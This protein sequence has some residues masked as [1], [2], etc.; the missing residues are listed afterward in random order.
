MP[1]TASAG[2]V[3]GKKKLS[4]WRSLQAKKKSKKALNPAVI[5]ND[6]GGS[7]A[8]AAV[9]AR[10]LGGE[11][12][13]QAGRVGVERSS[14]EL[15]LVEAKAHAETQMNRLQEVVVSPFVV[16]A[17][18]VAPET[19]GAPA[20]I[21][22][23]TPAGIKGAPAQIK[24][25]PAVTVTAGAGSPAATAGAD[26]KINADVAIDEIYSWL[27][28]AKPAWSTT[29][30]GGERNPSAPGLEC[31]D[32]G[33]GPGKK[34]VFAALLLPSGAR[35]GYG[36]SG[37][38]VSEG[39]ALG[40]V[41]MPMIPGGDGVQLG[42]FAGAKGVQGGA[43][44]NYAADGWS[45][46]AGGA[47]L[48]A[49]VEALAGV[50]VPL[51]PQWFSKGDLSA[52]QLLSKEVP[53]GHLG[54]SDSYTRL[55]APTGMIAATSAAGSI[56]ASSAAGSTGASTTNCTAIVKPAQEGSPVW[57]AAKEGPGSLEDLGIWAEGSAAGT[58]TRSAGKKPWDE[59]GFR[60]NME[61]RKSSEAVAAK[62]YASTGGVAG[63]AHQR[64]DERRRQS[65][66]DLNLN[67]MIAG[68][69]EAFKP[70]EAAPAAAVATAALAAA[71]GGAAAAAAG[72]R[73]TAAQNATTAVKACNEVAPQLV[74]ALKQQAGAVTEV[75]LVGAP[76]GSP[77]VEAGPATALPKAAAAA[78]PSTPE[79]WTGE[80][81]SKAVEGA[82]PV[83]A[84]LATAT[85]ASRTTAKRAQAPT[86]AKDDSKEAG[87][88]NAAIVGLVMLPS[89]PQDRGTRPSAVAAGPTC[90]AS[91]AADGGA[92]DAVVKE[93]QE[94][95]VGDDEVGIKTMIADVEGTAASILRNSS[96]SSFTPEEQ[97]SIRST[98]K[99][100]S[101]CSARGTWTAPVDSEIEKAAATASEQTSLGQAAVAGG[102]DLLLGDGI[103]P[104]DSS[105]EQPPLGSGCGR[106]RVTA[107]AAGD[108]GASNSRDIEV[109]TA[110]IE[111]LTT[112][113]LAD[114][115]ERRRTLGGQGGSSPF[116]DPMS[117]SEAAL[118]SLDDSSYNTTGGDLDRSRLELTMQQS[119]A[120]SAGTTAAQA[121]A[122]EARRMIAEA[123]ADGVSTAPTVP[124]E[125]IKRLTVGSA[126]VVNPAKGESWMDAAT[127]EV[128][129]A[130]RRILASR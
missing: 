60:N 47:G 72:E 110:D 5:G 50:G 64:N 69:I 123:T 11:V 24:G 2:G 107:T 90:S 68:P 34:S 92:S 116:E 46:S 122:A 102:L 56:A 30:G 98:G 15:G 85:E 99:A 45:V 65:G 59:G 75:S 39:G 22:G 129:E 36:P 74:G 40:G 54:D 38:S 119:S 10:I 61:R 104:V 97:N 51:V 12:L 91:D 49:T 58:G 26:K 79:T 16:T 77:Y 128:E 19:K 106:Q 111:A 88:D 21:T 25:A 1:T 121:A 53:V 118:P 41:S 44:A 13:N 76:E 83:A 95:Q 52:Q 20:E 124:A 114:A 14:G 86:A 84:A 48:S 55:S 80:G 8:A 89:L 71:Q 113:I 93:Q 42:G 130:A 66:A 62:K 35:G 17:V 4:L 73:G 127:A 28:I 120:T 115:Q 125:V 57:S 43:V 96:L 101:S 103:L 37:W 108:S 32:G 126:S 63:L 7:T 105:P 33:L 9:A 18:P 29:E 3:F 109:A 87:G 27:Q 23:A 67:S 94:N 6:A 78:V 31:K 82:A 117:A 112:K 81:S 100:T 70:A